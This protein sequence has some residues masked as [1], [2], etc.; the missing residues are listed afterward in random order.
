M[1]WIQDVRYAFRQLR[2]S[3]GFTVTATLTLALGIGMNACIFTLIHALLLKNLPVADPNTLVRI[4]DANECCV[5]G[6]T[7]EDGAYSLF[8]TE[9]WRLLKNNMPEFVEIAAM[10]AGFGYRPLTAR[11]EGKH[12][13]AQSVMGEFVSPNYFRTFGL[14]AYAGRM[15]SDRDDD[16]GAPP[17]AVMSYA[18]WQRAYAGD[19][20]IIGGT[21][22]INTKPVRLVGIAPA[23][24]F[25]DRLSATPAD[26]FLPIE[27]METL[28][29]TA[30]VH[31]P[32]VRWLY[33]IGRL[34]PGVQERPLQ[35]K[36]NALVLQS[37]AQTESFSKSE[38]KRLLAKTHVK[39]TPG[40]SGI[41]ELQEQ[42]GTNLRVLMAISGL[43]LLIACANVAN[44]LLARGMGRKQEMSLRTALGAS[45]R[46]IV[47]QLLIESVLLSMVGGVAGLIVSYTGTATL[48][49]LAFADAQRLPINPGPSLSVLM[50]AFGLAISTGVVFGIAPAWI[51]SQADPADALR[52]GT[53]STSSTASFIQRSLVVMQAGLALVLLTG[54]GLFSQ[55]LNKLQHANLRLESNNRYI[56]HLSPQAAGYSQ[57][58]LKLLYRTMEE[59]FHAIPG[60]RN[61]GITLYSPMEDN[62]WGTGIHLQ[63][64]PDPK[65]GASVVKINSEY[66][67][68]VGTHVISGRGITR[69]DGSGTASV[70]VVNQEFADKFFP[71]QSPIGRYFGTSP[72][73][74]GDYKIV[75][76]VENTTYTSVRWKQHTMYFL[77]I[78]QRPASDKQ[79]IAKDLSL[80]AGALVVQTER[81]IEQMPTV[82][83]RTLA[84]INPNLTVIKF[85]TFDQQVADR[86]TEERMIA[87]LTTVFGLLALLLASVGLYGVTAYT[88]TSR[89]TEIGVR[90][91]L[92]A[93]RTQ[94]IAMILRQAMAQVALGL[95]IGVPTSMLC[96]RFIKSQ[97]FD[98]NGMDSKVLM[99]AAFTLLVAAGLAGAIP[100]QRAAS[101]D[102]VSAL[103]AE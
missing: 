95:L 34:K 64:L 8:S 27:S 70:A 13:N 20:S 28:A 21:F 38:A 31:N 51:T 48:L 102:P 71:N 73:S 35:E 6:G 7:N 83:Q 68:S 54:A 57:T 50:F 67:D 76:V 97:L 85:Q 63:G 4:G 90:M 44:L 100:A 58:Q 32:D 61:V 98:M 52:T 41:Q 56:V 19:L 80:Y 14:N 96:V 82:V 65:A 75:G 46:Q 92:G 9:T 84:G 11:R 88:T 89:T 74:S 3:P 81:P 66:F 5:N 1:T 77:P 93:A 79:P 16:K 49:A 59:R 55:S 12:S 101:V 2:K 62:N 86:F 87:R 33:L 26:F 18:A 94:V 42:Y 37:L 53:R 36:L 103:R 24:F 43:V 39:L 17:T 60:V 91:A 10:Q 25:G 47:R 72:E 45:R 22:Y 30:Y 69:R 99:I 23:G 78:L 15:L 29:A 40:G